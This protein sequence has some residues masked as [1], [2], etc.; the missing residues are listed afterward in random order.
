MECDVY[1]FPSSQV[2]NA[3]SLM[4]V[5]REYTPYGTL[6]L[7]FAYSQGACQY[8]PDPDSGNAAMLCFLI[9]CKVQREA[10]RGL[11]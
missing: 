1:F 3:P 5:Y 4:Q 10:R 7:R 11:L 6:H 2:L 8:T 9:T